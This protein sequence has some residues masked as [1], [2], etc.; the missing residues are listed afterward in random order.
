MA[1]VTRPSLA[2]AAVDGVML[3]AHGT[4]PPDDETW[5]R[6]V[7]TSLETYRRT[8]FG[9]ALATS[10]GGAPTAA[11]RHRFDK[12][13]R[14]EVAK[15]GA[16]QAR[17]AIM[18]RSAFVRAVVTASMLFEDGWFARVARGIRGANESSRVYR[19]F[20]PS[21]SAQAL[22]WLG[23]PAGKDAALAHELERLRNEVEGI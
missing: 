12:R 1:R 7:S 2:F 14:E 16:L 6:L 3:I 8:Q 4:E 15:S 5:D 20:L 19:A 9:R 13:T 11:Q 21:E 17:I 23:V 10:E 18:S 22:A